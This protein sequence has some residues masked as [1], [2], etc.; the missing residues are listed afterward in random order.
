[1]RITSEFETQIKLGQKSLA[2]INLDLSCRDDIT[3]FLLDLQHLAKK[4]G[5]GK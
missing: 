3:K 5:G 4:S 1:M 2:S